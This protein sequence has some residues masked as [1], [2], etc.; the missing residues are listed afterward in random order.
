VAVIGGGLGG[1][2]LA[3]G[4]ARDGIDVMVYERDGSSA[5][6]RQGYRLHVDARAGV[7]LQR[8]LPAEVFELFLATCGRAGTKFTVLSE[9]LR[10]LREM[11]GDPSRDPYA[12]E[13]L[14]TS[15][16]RQTLREVLS[17]GIDRLVAYGHELT[18]YEATGDGV[19]LRFA[20]GTDADADVLVGADGVNSVVRR[21]YLPDADVVDSGSRCIYGKTPLTA[22]ALALVPPSLFDGFT[23][24]VA[25]PIGMATGLVRLRNRPE[26]VS[27][28]LSPAGDYLMWAISAKRDRFPSVLPSDPVELHAIVA[29]MIRGWHPDLRRLVALADVAEVFPVRIRTAVPVPPWTP[30]R[31]TVLGDAIHAMSPARGSGANTALRDAAVL[32]GCLVDARDRRGHTDVVTAIGGYEEQMRA[33]GFEAVRASN[34]AEASMGNGGGLLFWLYRH[35]ARR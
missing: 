15:V 14:S 26:Q 31:V 23:A 13:T 29:R 9:R 12:P 35:L 22:E 19:R 28:L 30:S 11:T 25:G 20:D 18:G 16:N 4:L 1:L 5:G 33:Y 8:C 10:V 17:V 6:R 7:A 21:A 24:I 32:T 2:C 3:Q 34:E 27:S